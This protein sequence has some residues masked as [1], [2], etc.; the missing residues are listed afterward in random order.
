L[1]VEEL[2]PVHIRISPFSG[3][4]RAS[5]QR[6]TPRGISEA[7]HPGWVARYKLLRPYRNQLQR[8]VFRRVERPPA[9]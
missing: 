4:R 7:E 2:E 3:V 1:L 8:V 5:R 9:S 6:L